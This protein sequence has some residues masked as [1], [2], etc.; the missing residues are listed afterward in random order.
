MW[1]PTLLYH[2]WLRRWC[3]RA[4]LFF[5]AII[6][7]L[8]SSYIMAPIPPATAT[9]PNHGAYVFFGILW[10]ALFAGGALLWLWHQKTQGIFAFPSPI[11]HPL[12]YAYLVPRM[13]PLSLC[14]KIIHTA[15][16]KTWTYARHTQAT[17]DQPL[18]SLPTL[19]PDIE[20][21]LQ[22]ILF[23]AMTAR[24]TIPQ[25]K[26]RLKEAFVVRYDTE[27]QS[28]LD[29]HRDAS[30]LT[31]SI[32]LNDQGEYLGGGTYFT[33]L[34]H[35]LSTSHAGDVLLHCGKLQHG[36]YP[37]R[38][39]VRYLLV[40]FVDCSQDLRFDHEDIASWDSEYPEDDEVMR[41]LGIFDVQ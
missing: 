15:E 32:A 39:G 31:A 41:R 38:S 21:F 20:D 18:R 7:F 12:R 11:D 3:W 34:N 14:Q 40:C 33:S 2:P 27:R 22:N 24:Y 35:V 37:V 26:L 16:Q 29:L 8:Q 1:F 9:P 23:P 5:F 13:M 25:H 17:Q 4:W 28:K 19:Q 30:L 36:G 10:S 6:L